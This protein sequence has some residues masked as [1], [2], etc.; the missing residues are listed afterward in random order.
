MDTYKFY[1]DE[2]EHSRKINY[3]TVNATN[4]Y[5]NC[6]AVIIGW[7][8]EKEKEIFEKYENFENK[9]LERKDRNR[10]LKSTTLKQKQFEYGF[11][12]LNRDNAQFL[13]DFLSIF[14]ESIKLYFSVASKI[15]YLVLQ[16]FISYRNNCF[17][18]ANAIKYSITKAL[19]AYRPQNV[20]KCIYDNPEEFVEELKKFFRE[21]IEYN[22]SNMSLKE[23]ENKAF[24]E[25]L[26]ILEDISV[27]PELG[28]DYHMPFA[29]FAKYLQ[30]EHIKNYA[31]LL[32]KEGEVD[33]A[34][35]TIQAAYEMGLSNV[36][37]ENSRNI[38]GLRV[39]DMMAGIISKLL[40]SLCDAFR[41]HS[42]EEGTEKKLLDAKWFQLNEVQLS[43]YKKLY[44]IICEW[45]N[46]WYKSYAGIYSDDLVSF[47]AL[48]GYM[49]H[50]ESAEQITQ[51]T[52]EKLQMQGEYFNG[53]VCQQLFDY[54]KRRQ[55]KMLIDVISE[56]DNDF[57]L[58]HRG[59]K[60]YYD[61]GKQPIFQI[62]EG[63]QA[64]MVLSVGIS[65]SGV[66]LITISKDNESI[67]YRLPKELSEWAYTVIEMANMGE[68]LFPSQV[69]FSKRKNRYFADIL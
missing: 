61:I 2:S 40:K 1:Y 66:P 8:K 20:I 54:F 67:C 46:A 27:I 31:L 10:E 36:T 4:Y 33:E 57:F 41:Y 64:V 34:S 22:K 69:V 38:Y 42:V 44:K 14:D 19:V 17:I 59:A 21:R 68:N 62:N 51:I 16:L 18:D 60:V 26:Y 28:W 7:S 35:K 11:A 43:L 9:Y 48:L 29:G 49:V 63:S 23:Q 58:N 5:D 45:D 52:N 3:K 12:S 65:K 37:E 32:D 6:I 56:T 47:I 25:I 30:E 53:Y 24:E 13:M 39:A 55:N 50:F 15:E